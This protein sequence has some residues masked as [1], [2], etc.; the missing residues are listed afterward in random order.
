MKKQGLIYKDASDVSD[1]SNGEDGDEESE[2]EIKE[3]PLGSSKRRHIDAG[4]EEEGE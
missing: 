1:E 2:E 3:I 4:D